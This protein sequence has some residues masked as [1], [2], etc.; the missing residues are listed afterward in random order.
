MPA[1][2]TPTSGP[3]MGGMARRTGGPRSGGK[4]EVQQVSE[5]AAWLRSY[6][7]FG[8]DRFGDGQFGP[9][10]LAMEAMD[11]TPPYRHPTPPHPQPLVD[12]A[13]TDRAAGMPTTIST[14]LEP[15]Q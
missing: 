10:P 6:D 14:A 1:A 7:G 3:Q 8:D 4:Q 13:S 12:Y 2:M 11:P 15:S 5:A 9:Y